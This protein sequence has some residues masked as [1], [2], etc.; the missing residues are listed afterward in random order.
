MTIRTFLAATLVTAL[1][2]GGALVLAQPAQRGPGGPG[3]PGIGGPGPRRAGPQ[4]DLGLRGI[5]L[6]DAQREQVRSIMESH[7]AEFDEAGK[8]LRDAHRAFAE[9]VHAS[10]IDEAT[11]RARSTAV[12]AAMADE[13]ILRAKVRSEVQA[14]LTPEQLEQLKQR[15]RRG[16]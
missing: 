10:P 4:A 11:I 2:S 5:D 15:P 12:A 8:K 1:A 14:I 6:T 9:A 3:G 13:A 7:K 16:K